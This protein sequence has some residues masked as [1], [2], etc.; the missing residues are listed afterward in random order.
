MQHGHASQ[1]IHVTWRLPS[2]SIGALPAAYAKHMSGDSYPLL[3]WRHCT[4]AEVCLPSCCLETGCITPSFY[5][6]VLDRVYRDVAWQ[7]V[8]QICYN[9]IN[10]SNVTKVRGS[11]KLLLTTENW[12]VRVVSKFIQNSTTNYLFVGTAS[13][14]EAYLFSFKDGRM[15]VRNYMMCSQMLISP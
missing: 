15:K 14:T 7:C 8:D 10:R 3:W 1:K 9:V 4:C 5:C 12:K 2:Q 6:C 11:S 13:I